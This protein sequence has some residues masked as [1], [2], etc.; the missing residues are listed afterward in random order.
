MSC[1]LLRAPLITAIQ[2]IAG[3]PCASFSAQGPL[4]SG[5]QS[6][7]TELVAAVVF[8][9]ASEAIVG[10]FYRDSHDV[11]NSRSSILGAP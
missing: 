8:P 9:P 4:S 5:Y 10:V 7:S 3:T 2:V 1:W 6:S 11:V